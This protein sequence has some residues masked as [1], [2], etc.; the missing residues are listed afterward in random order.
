MAKLIGLNYEMHKRFNDLDLD[1]RR[2]Q[3]GFVPFDRAALAAFRTAELGM[4][5]TALAPA[6]SI[7]GAIVKVILN[8]ISK[9]SWMSLSLMNIGGGRFGFGPGF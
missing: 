2:S 6:L 5:A 3:D 4:Q 1:Q 9:K 8:I 7:E